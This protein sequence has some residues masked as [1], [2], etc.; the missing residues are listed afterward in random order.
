[1]IHDADE[2]EAALDALRRGA[3]E[4]VDCTVDGYAIALL[5]DD[6]TLFLRGQLPGFSATAPAVLR[7]AL[8]LGLASA[9]HYDAGLACANF[10]KSLWLTRSLP[11]E[12]GLDALSAEV[13]LLL[14][15]LDVWRDSL[16]V[17]ATIPVAQAF[18]RYF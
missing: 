7:Q 6:D 14:E 2:F 3:L 8:Q 5:R 12:S 4:R 17:T 9:F 1:M 10:D 15:Q 13:E 16:G 18:E 11:A